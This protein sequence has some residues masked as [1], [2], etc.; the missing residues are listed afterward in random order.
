MIRK[1]GPPLQLATKEV[2]EVNPEELAIPVQKLVAITAVVN[3]KLDTAMK[4]CFNE[5]I[6]DYMSSKF[7]TFIADLPPKTS[8]STSQAPV[9]QIFN[10]S[11][12]ANMQSVGEGESA[13]SAGLTGPSGRSDH[14]LSLGLT[15]HWPDGRSDRATSLRWPV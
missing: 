3:K 13:Q 12:E 10:K 11:D 7:G 5:S 2:K 4:A 8:A 1:P 9:N 15:G 6:K 14:G